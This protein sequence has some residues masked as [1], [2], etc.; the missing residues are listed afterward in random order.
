M[1]MHSTMV[2]LSLSASLGY[3]GRPRSPWCISRFESSAS[4]LLTLVFFGSSCPINSIFRFRG[5]RESRSV[6]FQP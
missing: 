3:C 5:R 1:Q 2:G 4:R 6:E